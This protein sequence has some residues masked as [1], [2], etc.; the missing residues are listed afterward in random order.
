M[1]ELL[2]EDIVV[3]TGTEATPGSNVTVHYTG[4]LE[5]G[6][7]FDSSVGRAPF[8]FPLG[9]GR[10]IKG[11]DLGV[12]GMRVG[13]KRKLTIPGHLAYASGVPDRSSGGYLI[14]PNAT[15]LFD[16]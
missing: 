12:N 7:Q 13:G 6:K 3:G 8:S 10:V 16:V 4:T 5:N 1:S 14:P 11:W 15:L 9:G 2:I